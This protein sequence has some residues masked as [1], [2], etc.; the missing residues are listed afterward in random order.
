MSVCSAR[1]FLFA[2]V[3][4]GYQVITGTLQRVVCLFPA[5]CLEGG[6]LGAFSPR[7]ICF[8]PSTQTSQI[9]LSISSYKP[10]GNTRILDPH[11]SSLSFSSRSHT[12]LPPTPFS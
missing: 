12:T 1:P 8:T 4:A 7:I 10:E 2:Q 11:F 6:L 5:V 9:T 3:V